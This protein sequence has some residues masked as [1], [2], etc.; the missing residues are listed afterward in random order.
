MSSYKQY[1]K[2]YY[3]DVGN[4]DI[5]GEPVV[6]SYDDYAPPVFVGELTQDSNQHGGRLLDRKILH[7]QKYIKSNGNHKL[8]KYVLKD[9]E[10]LY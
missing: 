10:I 3:L 9:L 8:P 1:G 5:A 7:L 4:P 2:G 6:K